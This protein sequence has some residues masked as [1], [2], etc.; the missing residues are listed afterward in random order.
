MPEQAP[1]PR[2]QEQAREYTRSARRLLI[3]DLALGAVFLL[4]VLLSGL[5]GGLR[6]A[7]QLPQP[8]RV[9]LYFLIMMFSYSAIAAPITVYR[10]FVLPRRHGLSRQNLRSWLADEAKESGLAVL[11]GTAMVVIVYLLLEALPQTWWLAAF[12]FVTAVMV[13][14]SKLA[15]VLIVPLFL[16]MKPIDNPELRR[17]LLRLAE[18]CGTEV[19]DVY[20]IGFG[21]KTSAGNAALMG[22][23][24]TRRIVVSDTVLSD[25]TPEEIEVITAHEIGHQRHNDIAR[26]IAAQSALVLLGFYLA[27]LT[28]RWAV[29]R[30]DLGGV[31]DVA[32]LPLLALVMAAVFL[33]LAPLSNAYSR[34][35]EAAADGYA[36]DATGN[37]DA[38]A[39]MLT[40]LTDQNLA[41]SRPGRWA[42]IM[43]YDHPP[44]YKRLKLAQSHRR[45]EHACVSS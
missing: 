19:K 10:D 13:V 40:R 9:A 24:N 15:P 27:N 4:A 38:F 16:K 3:L 32:G 23:G 12:V 34:R 21:S 33:L 41:E 39:T 5:S 36:L 20:Q 18:R 6:D 14:L 7:L 31:S 8:A 42:E 11:L 43:L 35:L 44:Y 17:R 26:L 45:E 28:L 37:P 1:D 2:R 29:P 30:L 22:W 25:Y